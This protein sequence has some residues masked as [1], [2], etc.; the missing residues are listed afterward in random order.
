[1]NLLKIWDC[2]SKHYSVGII[3]AN[4][5]KQE[6][7]KKQHEVVGVDLGVKELAIVRQIIVG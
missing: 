6:P 1:M 7:T 5:Q 3:L 4:Y 2:L